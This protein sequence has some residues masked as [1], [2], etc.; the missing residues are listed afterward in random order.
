MAQLPIQIAAA[1]TGRSRRRSSELY[2]EAKYYGAV[3]EM[4]SDQESPVLDDVINIMAARKAAGEVVRCHLGFSEHGAVVTER[5]SGTALCQW[6]RVNMAT[7]ATVAHP[8]AKSRRIGLLKVREAT[9]TLTWHLFKY[10]VH[11]IDNMTECFQYV[12]ECGLRDLGRACAA[13]M[14]T[15]QHSAE[16]NEESRPPMPVPPPYTAAPSEAE[17]AAATRWRQRA[18]TDSMM[19]GVRDFAEN[20]DGADGASIASINLDGYME[21]VAH[22]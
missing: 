3:P 11:R 6:D 12:V 18:S 13:Q 19:S 10:Y 9:G 17:V 7:C 8:T 21:I 16:E 4:G 2:F 5:R 15:H 14:A 20:E 22:A 1:S